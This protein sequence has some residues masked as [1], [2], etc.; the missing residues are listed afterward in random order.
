MLGVYPTHNVHAIFS[1]V[2]SKED[3]SFSFLLMGA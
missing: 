3:E 1:E 2:L